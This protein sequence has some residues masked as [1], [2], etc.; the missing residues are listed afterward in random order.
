MKSRVILSPC[1]SGLRVWPPCSCNNLASLPA[2][3]RWP[4]SSFR[5]TSLITHIVF[6]NQRLWKEAIKVL[7]KKRFSFFLGSPYDFQMLTHSHSL[8]LIIGESIQLGCEF[9]ADHFNLFDNPVL[10]RKA[11]RQ[12][13]TQ[14]NMMGNL[15][16]PFVSARRF[17]VAFASVN[18]V[19]TL[20][21]TITGNV[22]CDA[23][24]FDCSS[25]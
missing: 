19:H 16:E 14:I 17:R 20:W 22:S 12:E 5:N 25:I 9:H 11:Q 18:N 15:L 24:L 10:W 8:R 4:S 6:R 2:Q 23:D 7:F 21:L 13:Q 1:A 3:R